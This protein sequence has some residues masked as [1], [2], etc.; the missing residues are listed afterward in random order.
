MLRDD[1]DCNEEE[2]EDVG[3][4]G[5]DCEICGGKARSPGVQS[6]VVGKRDKQSDKHKT[7]AIS[8]FDWP[9]CQ[10]FWQ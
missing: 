6:E 10:I 1:A 4:R 9:S 2:D 5:I 3:N 7:R 8:P